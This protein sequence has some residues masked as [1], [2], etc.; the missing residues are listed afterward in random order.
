[1]STRPVVAMVVGATAGE[2]RQSEKN[3]CFPEEEA[4]SV[5]DRRNGFGQDVDDFRAE[6]SSG[7]IKLPRGQRHARRNQV[8]QEQATHATCGS[9]C[10]ESPREH[11][12]PGQRHKMEPAQ[13]KASS[14]Y[15]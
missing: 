14:T 15:A 6:I 10:L 2:L 5:V 9:R 3:D 8:L 11:A 13:Q 1:M 12:N 4:K 7:H